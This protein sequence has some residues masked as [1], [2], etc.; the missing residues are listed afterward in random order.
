[1]TLLR[2]WRRVEPGP[3][4]AASP[5][6]N[7]KEGEAV[8]R[9]GK[10]PA[11]QRA[12]RTELACARALL[13]ALEAVLDA[14]SEEQTQCGV[15]LQ[16]AEQFVRVANTMSQWKAERSQNGV[17][18]PRHDHA[19]QLAPPSR[20]T[21]GERVHKHDSADW[22]QRGVTEERANERAQGGPLVLTSLAS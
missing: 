16:M 13:D 12:L 18:E 6:E 5:S 14:E 22:T 9:D 10:S 15:A 3:A 20:V 19:F 8:N 17:S 4:H 11:A 21:E 2:P 7:S 1:V